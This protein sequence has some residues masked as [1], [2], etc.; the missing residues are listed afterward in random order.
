MRMSYVP[1]GTGTSSVEVSN[2]S[3]HGFWLLIENRELFVPFSNF[4]WFLE[5]PIGTLVDVQA[6]H[7]GHLYW[8]QL[9]IDLAV[10]SIEHPERYPLVSNAHPRVAEPEDR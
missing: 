5:A 8:P 4:P 3:R 1:P 2:V 7:E 6:P 9:D 10:E